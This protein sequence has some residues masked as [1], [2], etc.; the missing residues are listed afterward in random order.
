MVEIQQ[1]NLPLLQNSASFN[2]EATLESSMV[3]VLESK[4]TERELASMWHLFQ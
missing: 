1:Q 3:N 2:N 4:F